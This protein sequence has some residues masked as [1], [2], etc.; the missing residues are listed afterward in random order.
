MQLKFPKGSWLNIKCSKVPVYISNV[1]TFV[2]AKSSSG[3]LYSAGETMLGIPKEPRRAA[4]GI[5]CQRH[6]F[7]F[8]YLV[9]TICARGT[10]FSIWYLVCTIFARG[11]WSAHCHSTIAQLHKCTCFCKTDLDSWSSRL[12]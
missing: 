2:S 4:F 7:Q 11:T 9:C 3:G 5:L 8:I 1:R 6:M 12:S 10:C